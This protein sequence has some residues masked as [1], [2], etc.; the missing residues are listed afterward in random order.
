MDIASFFKKNKNLLIILGI[1]FLGLFF[2]TYNYRE[3]FQ[4]GHEQ[5]LQAWIVKDILVDHHPRLIG[6]ETSILGVFIGP[7]YYYLLAIFFALFS[8]DPLSSV[9][10]VTSISLATLIS[11]YFVFSKLFSKETGYIGAFL[12]AISIPITFLDRWAVPTQPTLL[13][14]IWFLYVIMTFSRGDF[15]AIPIFILLLGFI[16]HIHIAFIPLLLLVGVSLFLSKKV[17]SFFQSFIKNKKK[18]IISFLF[19]F[20]LLLPFVV[21]ESRHGFQQTKSIFLATY[22]EKGAVS[23]VYKYELIFDNLDR[24]L[25]GFIFKDAQIPMPSIWIIP[26]T[27]IGFLYLIFF[28]YKRKAFSKN[29]MILVF[30]W[31]GD[32][33]VSHF[34][35]KR[36]LS[37][38]YFNNLIIVSLL[39]FSLFLTHLYKKKNVKPFVIIACLSFL[40]VNIYRLVTIQPARNEYQDKMN[41][42]T[43]IANDVYKNKYPCV[44]ITYIGNNGVSYGYRYLFWWKNIAQVSPGSGV[45]VYNLSIPYSISESEVAQTFGTIGVIL[46]RNYTIDPSVCSDPARQLERLNGFAN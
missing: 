20:I 21:F 4:Y 22:E 29:E 3:F 8:F 13:W 30:V 14:I 6:Q 18:V 17:P 2:R 34:V 38:Y 12:Y 26:I 43:F 36:P 33:F 42:I 16:W 10:L 41:A 27:L 1:F 44:G 39:V 28:L 24:V 15:S 7:L 19:A 9:V 31:I 23:G 25:T 35:S 5:D 37:E 11:V 32:V 40:I 46:P 45:P